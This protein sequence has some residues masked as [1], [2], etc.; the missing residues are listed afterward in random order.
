MKY[1]K[2]IAFF[3]IFWL[4]VKFILAYL[5]RPESF[6]GDAPWNEDNTPLEYV[7]KGKSPWLHHSVHYSNISDP[8][9]KYK[10]AY[11]YEMSNEEYEKALK[12]IFFMK[13]C[14][15]LQLALQSTEWSGKL[16]PR[17]V[18]DA[19]WVGV[20]DQWLSEFTRT[21][22]ESLELKLSATDNVEI[23]V[24]HDRW[25]SAYTHRTD[26]SLL[27]MDIEVILY[28]FG[29]PYGKHVSL[30]VIAKKKEPDGMFAT[31]NDWYYTVVAI[32]IVGVVPEDQIAIFPVVANNPFDPE[33]M[34]YGEDPASFENTIVPPG[35]DVLKEIQRRAALN[36]ATAETQKKL[37]EI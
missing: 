14:D 6:L 8:V 18:T 7:N 4:G 25:I 2:R 9:I 1:I 22:N 37:G 33:Q 21:L 11:Y 28:R 26:P 17:T 10:N 29:K 19:I 3:A 13:K 12:Q 5:G 32:E 20:Y 36:V 16:N 15:S 31:T 35:Q 34:P 27:R 23:Q 24:V 30:S